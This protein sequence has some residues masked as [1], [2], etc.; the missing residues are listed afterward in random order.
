MFT[1]GLMANLIPWKR[2]DKDAHYYNLADRLKNRYFDVDVKIGRI[3]HGQKRKMDKAHTLMGRFLR[4]TNIENFNPPMVPSAAIFVRMILVHKSQATA[5][6]DR[7]IP[8]EL[9]ENRMKN[10]HDRWK[11]SEVGLFQLG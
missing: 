10:L 2:L 9:V 7:Y 4:V 8:L 6:R 1:Q 11:G 3:G 5:K